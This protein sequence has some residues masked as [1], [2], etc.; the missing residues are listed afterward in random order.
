MVDYNTCTVSP[1]NQSCLLCLCYS[2]MGAST[3]PS[4][5]PTNLYQP[6]SN[7][8]INIRVYLYIAI[9]SNMG[10]PLQCVYM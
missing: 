9:A 4:N 6:P 7:P 1:I 2:G 10:K 8:G 3:Q 5:Q